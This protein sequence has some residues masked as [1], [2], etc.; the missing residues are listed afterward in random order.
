MKKKEIRFYKLNKKLFFV[1]FSFSSRCLIKG[2]NQFNT[3][4]QPLALWHSIK[5]YLGFK[6]PYDSAFS[7]WKSHIFYVFKSMYFHRAS[8]VNSSAFYQSEVNPSPDYP[9]QA[10]WSYLCELASKQSVG[11]TITK[12]RLISPRRFGR[13]ST[14]WTNW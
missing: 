10:N 4:S 12:S 7:K 5:L 9:N 11:L 1:Y 13:S 2:R 14:D 6:L 3:Q 8:K